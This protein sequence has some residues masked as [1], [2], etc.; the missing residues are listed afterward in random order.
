MS[1]PILILTVAAWFVSQLFFYPKALCQI[2]ISESKDISQ[3]EDLIENFFVGGGVEVS[4]IQ[5]DGLYPQLATFKNRGSYLGIREGLVMVTGF[6]SIVQ[7]TNPAAS[8]GPVNVNDASTS[9]SSSGGDADLSAIV[10]RPTYDAISIEFDFVPQFDFLR[11]RYVFASEEYPEYN[12]T[13]FNDVFAFLLS[14]PAYQVPI[15]IAT[16][17]GTD[18]AVAI[19]SINDGT[20]LPERGRASNCQPPRGATNTGLY[21]DNSGGPHLEFDGLTLVLEAIAPVTPCEKHHI[22]L[23]I[24]D[25]SDA[26]LDSGVFFEAL[27]FESFPS[28]SITANKDSEENTAVEGCNELNFVVSLNEVATSD[29]EFDIEILGTAL[30]GID[31]LPISSPLVIPAGQK[32]TTFSISPIVDELVEPPESVQIVYDLP[33]CEEL[34]DTLEVFIADSGILTVDPPEGE[35]CEG[36]ER[37]IELSAK[38]GNLRGG[39]FQWTPTVGLSDPNIANPVATVDTAITYTVIYEGGGCRDTATWKA[40]AGKDFAIQEIQ[41]ERA[42]EGQPLIVGADVTAGNSELQYQWLPAEAFECSD[43]PQARLVDPLDRIDLLITTA[44]GCTDSA[45]TS[46]QR[47]PLLDKPL[48]F[49]GDKSF[50]AVNLEWDPVPRATGYR[51]DLNDSIFIKF[52]DKTFTNVDIPID[53]TDRSIQM[54]IRALDETG[55]YCVSE[56]AI[57]ECPLSDCIDSE[58]CNIFVPNVF[59]PNRDGRNDYFYVQSDRS[60]EV[61]RSLKIF[62]R[63][64]NLVFEINDFAPNDTL[65]GWDGRHDGKLVNNGVFVWVVEVVFRDGTQS[66]FKGDVTVLK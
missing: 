62:D 20:F 38:V 58:F 7:T 29:Q 37:M 35:F 11:F 26:N 1:K 3:F 30:P 36:G 57:L 15:N 14:G 12:C 31:F 32:N 33:S 46:I 55:T 45:T 24:A 52:T 8:Q 23:A 16:I 25:V 64:G 49:C 53:N 61:I 39:T 40:S 60:V 63:N 10:R 2:E 65:F 17:P 22:K 51:I 48:P 28:F 50:N 56:A 21:I 9:W 66:L 47:S 13:E 34:K 44:L 41:Y 43:C 54:S 4:N 42:C 18:M 27:S 5:F 59:S 19:N 6:S